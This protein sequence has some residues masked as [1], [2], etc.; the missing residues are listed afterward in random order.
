MSYSPLIRSLGTLLMRHLSLH[1]VS[2]TQRPAAE[3]TENFLLDGRRSKHDADGS[4]LT[5][6]EAVDIVGG[7]EFHLILIEEPSRL[8]GQLSDALVAS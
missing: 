6:A 3:L 4:V 1:R 8:L 2:L 7:I 5:L